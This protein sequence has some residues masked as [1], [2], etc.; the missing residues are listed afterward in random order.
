MQ[1]IRWY[2]YICKLLDGKYVLHQTNYI[3]IVSISYKLFCKMYQSYY[4]RYI[5]NGINFIFFI[6]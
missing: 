1:I 2:I 3:W 4:I 6:L 5:L